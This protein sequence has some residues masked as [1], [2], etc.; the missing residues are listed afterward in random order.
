M[1]IWET[2]MA[3]TACHRVRFPAG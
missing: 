2:M 3:N 1:N